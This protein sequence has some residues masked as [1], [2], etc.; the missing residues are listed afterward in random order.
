MKRV[1]T[2]AREYGSGGGEVAR[3]L[4]DRL[5]WR[6]VDDALV[7]RFA[8]AINA[9]TEAVKACDERVDP[10]FHRTLKAFWHGGVEGAMSRPEWDPLDSDAVAELW[11][12]VIE[13]AGREGQCVTVGRGGQC[14]LKGRADTFHVYLYAPVRERVERIRDREPAGRDLATAAVQHDQRRN[15]YIRHY[16]GDNWRDPHLYDLMVCSSMGLERVAD[17]ILMAAGLEAA[18]LPTS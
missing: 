9:P 10:W 3:I 14:I 16:F 15:D 18:P 8:K 4:A 2:I 12:R 11:N 7:E 13:Q 1:I 5:D 17:V 6:I